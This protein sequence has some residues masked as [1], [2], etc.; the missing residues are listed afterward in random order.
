MMRLFKNNR[1]LFL[2][3]LAIFTVLIWRQDTSAGTGLLKVAFLDI[4]Q[5]DSIYIQAPNGRQVLIDGGRDQKVLSKLSDVMPYGD[6][7]LDIV[8]ATH[9]DA[10]H[11]GGLPYILRDYGVSLVME[12][13]V[14]SESDVYKELEK[15][16]EEEKAEHV[17]ASRGMVIHLDEEHGVDLEILFPDRDTTG[18][19]TNEASIVA[20]L[21][22]GKTSFLLTGDAP[23]STELYLHKLNVKELD[24]DVL[25]LGHHGSRT[26]TSPTFIEDTT[27]NYA[28]ISAGLNNDYGHPHK[29]VLDTLAYYKVPYLAT[30]EKG[31][32]VFES[33]GK[34]LKLKQN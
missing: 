14:Q 6:R 13:G 31:T 2:I 34:E 24:V 29:E 32:I 1:Y 3:F 4:G 33:D 15:S 19:E 12:P 11:I 7:T 10:D 9:P 20:K 26:S 17:F 5:G 16:I 8:I 23:R 25:K 21:V 27:P 18:W 28:I 30:Y 22:Y